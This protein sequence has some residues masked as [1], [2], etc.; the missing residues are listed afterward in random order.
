[1]SSG[2]ITSS[3]NSDLDEIEYLI[4]E[5]QESNLFN[6]LIL[7]GYQ[8]PGRNS[9][10]VIGISQLSRLSQLYKNIILLGDFIR[11]IMS[12]EKTDLTNIIEEK[13]FYVTPYGI[14]HSYNYRDKNNSL[15]TT[16]TSIDI[17]IVGSEEKIKT[18]D[19]LFWPD[20]SDHYILF[21][22]YKILKPEQTQRTIKYLCFRNRDVNALSANL[23]IKFANIYDAMTLVQS[24]LMKK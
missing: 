16:H 22:K 20:M 5:I 21:L 11:N 13:S 18:F 2:I 3:S 7:S 12:F 8:R 4:F 23:S 1:M 24:T 6:T 15:Q 10:D 19:K 14:T 9:L 17:I